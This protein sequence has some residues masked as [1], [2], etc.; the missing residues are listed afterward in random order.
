VPNEI[1]AYKKKLASNPEGER[2]FNTVSISHSLMT[3]TYDLVIDSA[4]LTALD[5]NAVSVNYKPA[6]IN[7]SGAYQSND[8]D[9]EATYTISDEQNTLDS[10]LELIPLDNNES[11]VVVFRG[12]MSG[13]LDKPVETFTY[14]VKAISQ[15]K[16]IFTLKTGVPD[17]NSDQTG[18]IYDLDT[19]P[20]MR[21]LF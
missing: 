7:Y 19:Y 17:L 16:G 3:K 2:Y 9:Q 4:P 18:Q 1:E 15:E 21:S 12:Y 13:Y 20:M 11:P 8:L 14:Q 6:S 10:E 5:E